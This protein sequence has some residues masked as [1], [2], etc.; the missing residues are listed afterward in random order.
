MLP[1]RPVM[2]SG[3]GSAE[4]RAEAPGLILIKRLWDQLLALSAVYSCS[5]CDLND[6]IYL[7]SSTKLNLSLPA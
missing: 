4:V 7:S 2:N 3:E 5:Y 6:S 1:S